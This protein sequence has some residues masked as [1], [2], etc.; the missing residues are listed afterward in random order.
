M[1]SISEYI[2]IRVFV[3]LGIKKVSSDTPKI[4]GYG[5]PNSIDIYHNM[6]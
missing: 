6:G 5:L 1:L 3:I 2:L 4:I